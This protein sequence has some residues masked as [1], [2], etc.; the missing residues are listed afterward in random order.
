MQNSKLA[1]CNLQLVTCNCWRAGFTLLEL[2]LAITILGM[3]A[4]IIGSGFR[5]G[6]KA[7]EK[8]ESEAAETQQLRTLSSLISQSL[9]SAYPYKMKIDDKD[10][11]IFKGEKDSILFVTTLLDSSNRGFRWVRF[12]YKDKT[13]SLNEGILPDKKFMDK[14][15]DK[16]EVVDSNIREVWFEYFSSEKAEWQETWNLGDGI[17]AAVRVKIGYFQPFF[18]AIPMGVKSG[19]TDSKEKTA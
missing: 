4:I 7:W 14:L 10:T 1:T 16:G 15:E 19:D 13:L 5:L 2:I 9:K 12:S 3:V 6:I 18:I 17:P 8:G 11:I